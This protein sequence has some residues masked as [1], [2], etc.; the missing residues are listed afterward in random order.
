MNLPDDFFNKNFSDKFLRCRCTVST[1]PLRDFY[2]ELQ[3]V[4][5]PDDWNKNNCF[6]VLLPELYRNELIKMVAFGFSIR[7]SYDL[8]KETYKF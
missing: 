6:A 1:K 8:L 3:K 7:E 5:T 4:C 2:T